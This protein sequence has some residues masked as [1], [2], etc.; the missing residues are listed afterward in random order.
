MILPFL[1]SVSVQVAQC[2]EVRGDKG[3][4]QTYQPS[5]HSQAFGFLSTSVL[6]LFQSLMIPLNWNW[7]YFLFSKHA[8]VLSSF[9]AGANGISIHNLFLPRLSSRKSLLRP[10]L[11]HESPTLTF[12]CPSVV[13]SLYLQPVMFVLFPAKQFIN[14]QRSINIFY[15]LIFFFTLPTQEPETKQPSNKCLWIKLEIETVINQ[16]M[17]RV[18]KFAQ[19]F[20]E[21]YIK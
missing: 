2:Q 4:I 1:P 7:E 15:L 12:P 21:N 16:E 20:G 17:A 19:L 3:D 8:L 14:S 18:N 6:P 13:L 5:L 10:Y 9:Y 11:F